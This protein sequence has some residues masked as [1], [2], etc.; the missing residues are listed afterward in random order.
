MTARRRPGSAGTCSR[1]W[2]RQTRPLLGVSRWTSAAATEERW[3]LSNPWAIEWV[4]I[5]F[6]REGPTLFADAHAL[7]FRSWE[8]RSRVLPGHDRARSESLH[9]GGGGGQGPEA[10]RPSRRRGRVRRAFSRFLPP[11]QRLGNRLDLELDRPSS[12]TPLEL[13]R[14]APCPGGHG[15]VSGDRP[16]AAARGRRL[17]Q[18]PGTQSPSVASRR[19]PRARTFSRRAGASPSQPANPGKPR[20]SKRQAGR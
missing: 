9:R 4:G 15:R 5:D 8:L 17:Q 19:A 20:P 1:S 10:R 7:P 3:R 14:H 18:D 16:L 13:P 12:G 6:P 11:C 2:A